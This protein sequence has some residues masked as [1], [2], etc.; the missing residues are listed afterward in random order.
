MTDTATLVPQNDP[1][2]PVAAF[3]DP[4]PNLDA[5][6]R[7]FADFAT[8]GESLDYAACGQRGLN[9][10]DPR[11]KLA[12]VYPFSELQIDAKATARRLIAHGLKPGD[13]IA[14]IA[15][16]GAEFAAMFCGA[17]YAGV[18]PVPLPLPTSF[19]G[20][21]NYIEQLSVQLGSSEPK[22]LI[23]PAEISEMCAASAQR[24]G[25][26]AHSWEDFALRDAPDCSFPVAAP[27]DICFLQ[28]SSGSTR[29]PHGVAIT[30]R[31]LLS[32]VA[33][34]ASARTTAA[35]AGCHGIMTWGWSA[36]CCR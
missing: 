13:R 32:N 28:Y 5:L 8:F 23:F 7:R 1:G 31:S 3:G 10:H 35:S 30:H 26:E 17:V 20:K 15:E 6:P 33:A 34:H 22:M 16:T 2:L 27:D 18:L 9:F 29:F 11:G 24:Q 14:L 12:R 21:E 36:A 19:G 4:T 25:C